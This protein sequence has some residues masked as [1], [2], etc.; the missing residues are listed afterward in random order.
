MSAF[1]NVE[2]P[3]TI[4]GKLSA[5]HR[6]KRA[7]ELLTRMLVGSLV[8]WLVGSLVVSLV[9]SFLPLLEC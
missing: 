8:G 1:E 2:L 3:M 7:V 6:R 5:K 9:G 4:L